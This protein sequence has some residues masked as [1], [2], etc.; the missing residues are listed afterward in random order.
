LGSNKSAPGWEDA[1]A[2]MKRT[3]RTAV[4]VPAGYNGETETKVYKFFLDKVKRSE[5]APVEKP[6]TPRSRSNS[7]SVPDADSLEVP[8]D[9]VRILRFL[10]TMDSW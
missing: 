5:N 7:T 1:L 3:Q 8:D 4:L 10:S 9:S 2:G 6:A